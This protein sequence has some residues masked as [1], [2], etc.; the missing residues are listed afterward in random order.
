MGKAKILSLFVSF[1]FCVESCISPPPEENVPKFSSHIALTTFDSL[2]EIHRVWYVSYSGDIY[3]LLGIIDEDDGW[4]AIP[5]GGMYL[6]RGNFRSDAGN[7][8]I[9]AFSVT[10]DGANE[11]TS[12]EYG[13]FAGVDGKV[14]EVRFSNKY[15]FARWR[16]GEIPGDIASGPLSAVGYKNFSDDAL[17]YKNAIVAM[18]EETHGY[19]YYY[20]EVVKK[21]NNE[22]GE[23][24]DYQ[25]EG[26][27]KIEG[28][29]GVDQGASIASATLEPVYGIE[30]DPAYFIVRNRVTGDLVGIQKVGSLFHVMTL[31]PIAPPSVPTGQ[32]VSAVGIGNEESG[33]IHVFA[34]D[35]W[36]CLYHL[37]LKPNLEIEGGW[38]KIDTECNFST[39][40]AS[41]SS[42]VSYNPPPDAPSNGEPVI[43]V[44]TIKLDI[45]G[46]ERNIKIFRISSSNPDLMDS[47][48]LSPY[49]REISGFYGGILAK[50]IYN[51]ETSLDRNLIFT[52]TGMGSPRKMRPLFLNE[53]TP[54]PVGG[55]TRTW[56]NLGIGHSRGIEVTG[57]SLPH[58]E[59]FLA[60]YDGNN[61]DY[62][63]RIVA[64][65]IVRENPFYVTISY[66]TDDGLSWIEQDMRL[67]NEDQPAE[68]QMRLQSDPTVAFGSNG[69]AFVSVLEGIQ[70]YSW[71]RRECLPDL[72]D[73]ENYTS[74]M[75][76]KVYPVRYE[77]GSVIID[78]PEVIA[79]PDQMDHPWIA[80]YHPGYGK[81]TKLFYTWWTTV[82]HN[83][84][85]YFAEATEDDLHPKN[86]GVVKYYI[87]GEQKVK[88]NP[89]VLTVK[90]DGKVLLTYG[91]AWKDITPQLCH[92]PDSP[93]ENEWVCDYL[94]DMDVAVGQKSD[95]RKNFNFD[96]NF[97]YWPANSGYIDNAQPWAIMAS[98][99]D[100]NLVW[101][102]F[103]GPEEGN[104]GCSDIYFSYSN[105]G[106][107][108][109]SQAIRLGDMED[110]NQC[111]EQFQPSVSGTCDGTIFV[112]WFDMGLK[113]EGEINRFL[114]HR[115]VLL[116]RDSTGE[117]YQYSSIDTIGMVGDP[118]NLP[119]HCGRGSQS[120]P[121]HFPGEYFYATGGYSHVHIVYPVSWDGEGQFTAQMFHDIV[122]PY[123]F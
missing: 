54:L 86:T 22:W 3:T 16:T 6:D 48:E 57:I 56:K 51:S 118:E 19:L 98:P 106:G 96:Y 44:S 74:P 65:A 72:P 69:T 58:G 120:Y 90:A 32:S 67:I 59:M 105:D 123:N 42:D 94:I 93:I 33:R 35:M 43:Y 12:Y 100:P 34:T 38:R 37:I 81:P 63:G 20:S 27:E 104:T 47:Y 68:M 55:E 46:I 8:G 88:G 82:Y 116:K 2:N 80:S 14:Y 71:G 9:S 79:G 115:G 103:N 30:G 17:E 92:L 66:S 99:C 91:F 11:A 10:Y 62:Q 85:I 26:F 49:P 110:P 5:G 13:Y 75:A 23:D 77:G 89:P 28:V 39:R 18:G 36:H 73:A 31:P 101:Y 64:A 102:A 112:S 53:T 122:T 61:K 4:S 114:T 60:E 78:K 107:I 97:N 70:E 111:T 109:W 29:E 1:I 24:Q 121:A 83:E 113:W 41:L 119:V 52:V 40:M 87:N 25:M 84:N 117:Y 45:F 76:V 15:I 95:T 50:N 7:Y 108:T 21:T